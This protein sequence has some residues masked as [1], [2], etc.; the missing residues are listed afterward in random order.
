MLY[1][2]RL[3]GQELSPEYKADWNR[4]AGEIPFRRWEWLANWWK[5]FCG[6]SELFVL[7]ARDENGTIRGIAPWHLRKS[8]AG[9][10]VIE[11]L[12]NG[13]VCTDYLSLLC[14]A[15]DAKLVAQSV[16]KWLGEANQSNAIPG[17]NTWDLLFLDG[18]AEE[19]EALWELKKC[20]QS[21]GC[22]AHER[23]G[24]RAWRMPLHGEW[25]KYLGTL[26]KPVRRQ[27]RR[28]MRKMQEVGDI[29]FR[30][31][32]S[33]ENFEKGFAI[34]VDLHQRRWE[35]IGIEGCFT[36]PR[37]TGFLRDTSLDFLAQGKMHLS[38]LEHE[39]KP[40]VVNIEFDGGNID[41][42]YQGGMDP[43]SKALSPGWMHMIHL[44]QR[45]IALGKTHRDYMRGDEPYKK[46]W[47][48]HATQLVDL[49]IVP[50]HASARLRHGVW[51]LGDS[52][53]HWMKQR[54]GKES[55][56]QVEPQ[57]DEAEATENS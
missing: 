20:L 19:D 18:V 31:V 43:E 13:K 40:F 55:V 3:R 4:L 21:N 16:A 26:S 25:D 2:E 49:R 36:D 29:T 35:E 23:P 33:E 32:T 17:A 48:G 12:G 6:S 42:V 15:R 45:S 24:M 39:G 53:K 27:A 5:H 50:P 51:K 1:I 9:G 44:F 56:T 22:A 30:E 7:I 38:W 52:L 14:E 47:R 11:P 28:T 34:L 57:A 54:L 41:Y 46:H 8:I 37:F 10:R